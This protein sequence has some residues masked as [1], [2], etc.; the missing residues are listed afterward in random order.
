MASELWQ[1]LEARAVE[2]HVA[3]H[4]RHRLEAGE[5]LRV[6]LGL[7]PTA[8]DLHLGHLVV[9]DQLRE[10]Q[11]AGHTVVAIVGD[12]TAL[13]G[14]P[15]GR[16]DTR[17]VL[18]PEQVKANSQTY[19]EQIFKIL[20]RS[21][22][23][24]HG[25]SEWLS[26]LGSD[27]ILRLLGGQTLQAVL[28]REDF[29]ERMR[30]GSPI[31]AHEILYPFTQ[32]YDSVAVRA[33]LEIG[34]SDQLFNLLFGREIQRA[35]GQ[36]AQDVAVFPLLEGTDGERK[37]SKSLGNW[38]G[39][40]EPPDQIYGKTMSIPDNLIPKYLTLISGLAGTELA[41]A[42]SLPPREAKAHL[43]RTLVARLWDEAAAAEAER[44]F[45]DRFRRRQIAAEDLA[46]HRPQN[47][48]DLVGTLVELGWYPTRSMARRVIEQGGTSLDGSPI[49]LTT[50]LRD[51]AVL[52]A[53]RRNYVRI[54]VG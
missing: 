2:I 23:E 12:F 40:L 41:R 32:G 10:F 36:P 30:Q 46:E 14:D 38:I 19:F 4:L 44:R 50:E 21:R 34:G 26:P 48:S 49:G 17:P 39:L 27:G 43:A 37:M 29:A 1:R 3:A 16:S 45:D 53:G 28:Q 9:L 51:G 42:L 54:R 11:D 24:I 7:D 5:H 18:T 25:N 52:R 6:K 31:G 15:S 47:P 35:Y 33:D 8:P 20:D 13:I 22:T